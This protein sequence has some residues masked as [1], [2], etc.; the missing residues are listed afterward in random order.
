[1]N[2][3]FKQM[4]RLS[5]ELMQKFRPNS[6]L[7]YQSLDRTFSSCCENSVDR[8]LRYHHTIKQNNK[9]LYFR[10]G[11]FI[12]TFHGKQMD[13][14][15]RTFFRGTLHKIG[16]LRKIFNFPAYKTRENYLFYEDMCKSNRT[17]LNFICK[18]LTH[19]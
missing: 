1:M 9:L 3:I 13:Y 4:C 2:V 11:D 15:N 16:K 6:G 12:Q 10:S 7:K 8:I 19:Q 14:V 5:Y 18:N 17:N